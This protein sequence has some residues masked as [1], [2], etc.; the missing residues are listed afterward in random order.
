MSSNAFILI[1]AGSETTATALSGVTYLLLTHTD[2]LERL[3]QEVRSTFKSADEININSVGRL[4]YMLAVLNEAL[5]M[6]P[7]ATANLVR[8]VPP[9]GAYIAGHFVAG[10]VGA[11]GSDEGFLR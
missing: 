1:L 8:Q 7:P 5:R 3:K 9:G 11:P 4:S 6:Y 10:G 2:V